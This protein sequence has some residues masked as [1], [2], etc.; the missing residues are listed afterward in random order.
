MG[1]YLVSISQVITCHFAPGYVRCVEHDK[2]VDGMVHLGDQ[3]YAG[4]HS[5]PLL[6]RA[7]LCH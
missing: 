1:R 2:D 7:S 4:A 6:P 3:V 5:F